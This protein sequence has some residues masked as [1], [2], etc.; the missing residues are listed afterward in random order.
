[1]APCQRFQGCRVIQVVNGHRSTVELPL[2][3]SAVAMVR[4][5]SVLGQNTC[6]CAFARWQNPCPCA[7]TRLMGT[8][9]LSTKAG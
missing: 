3:T 8:G 1:M 5:S 2:H 7:F 6:P 9:H 4:R